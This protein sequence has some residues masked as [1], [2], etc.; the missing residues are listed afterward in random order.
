LNARSTRPA[1]RS[2]PR[3]KRTRF[4]YSFQTLSR[5]KW[6]HERPSPTVAAAAED[7]QRGIPEG[8]SDIASPQTL[9]GNTADTLDP[10][11]LELAL[12]AMREA[13]L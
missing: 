9:F 11:A 1:G 10:A 6:A 2:P 5:V 3:R 13:G 12:R 8:I 4:R 7:A